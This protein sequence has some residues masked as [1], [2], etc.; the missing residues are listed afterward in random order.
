[1]TTRGIADFMPIG[2]PDDMVSFA[3]LADVLLPEAAAY[4]DDADTIAAEDVRLHAP[5][6]RPPKNVLCVD[7][8][9][10]GAVGEFASSGFDFVDT[11]STPKD[12]VV[13]SKP[14]TSIIGPDDAIDI[15]GDPDSSVDFEGELALIIAEGG[16]D[17]A[18]ADALAH[19]LGYTIANDV[20]CR[21]AQRDHQQWLLAKGRDTFCPLGPALVTADEI[22]DPGSLWVR[23]RVN[24]EIRQEY[25][26]DSLTFGV[27]EIV[28]R[29]SRSITLEPGDVISCGTGPGTALASRPPRF[30]SPGD[31]VS[32]EVDEIGILSNAVV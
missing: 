12:V 30:L 9:H 20:T 19:V 27:D 15:G 23:T 21:T 17:I 32:V 28:S 13:S 7:F 3:A 29:I 1:M 31:V 22:P 14:A 6:S 11:R 8:N 4:L 26:I 24:G 18:P 25:G 2:I 16:S 10:T 5:I